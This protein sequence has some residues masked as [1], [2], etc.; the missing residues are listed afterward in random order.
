MVK[1][2][3][4]FTAI[5]GQ[6]ELLLGIIL[7]IINPKLGGLLIKGVKGSGKSTAVYSMTDIIPGIDVLKD[8]KFN[9][10]PEKPEYWC[11]DCRK[12]YSE[13]KRKLYPKKS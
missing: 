1:I 5:V 13:E 12:K 11:E 3:Y 2:N 6:E 9:C 7:N 10:N 4:P 8:C